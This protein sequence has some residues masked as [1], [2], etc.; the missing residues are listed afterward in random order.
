MPLPS[1]NSCPCGSAREY[2]ICCQRFISGSRS[3]STAEELMRSR[4]TAYTVG[5]IDYLIN[6]WSPAAR[7]S[8][9]I[10]GIEA[11]S[12]QSQWLGLNL[13]KC[14]K[15]QISDTEGWVEF[16]AYFQQDHTFTQHRELSYFQKIENT[17]YFTNGETLPDLKLNRNQN[18]VCGSGKK[19][20]RCCGK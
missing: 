16:V 9:D 5:A 4:Y 2:Q 3:A 1:S 12:R 20:K 10:K 7:S 19:F 6:T 15:G 18:C 17:W 11:W 14:K 8:L 13:L